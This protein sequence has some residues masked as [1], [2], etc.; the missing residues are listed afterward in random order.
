MKMGKEPRINLLRY[1]Q[2]ALSAKKSSLRFSI[3]LGLIVLLFL[4]AIAGAW[5]TQ[6]Q[7]LGALNAENQ[8]LQQEVDQ[9][10]V[11]AAK[12]GTGEVD[13]ENLTAREALIKQLTQEPKLKADQVLEVYELSD[14]GVTIGTMSVKAGESV[15]MSA[16][17]SSQADFIKFLDRLRG[18]D[19]IKEV[20]NV[21]SKRNAKT[22]EVNFNITLVWGVK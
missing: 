12:I 19:Y 1:R 11:K 14:P 16:Y 20:K 7:K 22:G 4:G 21:S 2:E 9:L 5:W 10:T 17:C 13:K 8:Q 3:I 15:T 6:T 18:L